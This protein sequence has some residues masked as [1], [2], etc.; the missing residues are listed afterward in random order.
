MDQDETLA[1][2]RSSI[3]NIDAALIHLLA[4]RF[5]ITKQVGEY[6]AAAGL[7]PADPERENE[8]IAR[9]RELAKDANLDPAFSEKFLR[10]VLAEVIRHH[11]RI[12]G[13]G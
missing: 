12:A 2:Y 6:K 5:K 9:L 11:E 7:P 10:F 8:Q 3:D 1:G 13:A 4:E